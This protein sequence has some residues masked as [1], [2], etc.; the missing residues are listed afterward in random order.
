IFGG[1]KRIASMATA[2]VPFMAIAYILLAILIIC[3]NLGEVPALFALIFKSALGLQSTFGGIVGAMIEIGV[4]RGL[5]SNEAGQGT[6]P[7]AA[8][9]AEVSHPAKQGLV[10][11]FSVYIDTLFVCTATALIILLS[12]TYN[13]TDG[14]SMSDGKASMIKDNGIFVEMSNG[15]KD[16]SGTA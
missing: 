2:V 15:D 1:I 3:L 8:A 5:Y 16:Y 7:H 4:K 11:S 14:G 13:V 12:G 9:A 6:G 10:Q